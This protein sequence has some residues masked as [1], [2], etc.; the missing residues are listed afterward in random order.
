MAQCNKTNKQQLCC[1]HS[2]NNMEIDTRRWCAKQLVVF[3][4]FCL[5]CFR[6]PQ[7]R[8]NIVQ[9]IPFKD[10]RP[11][12][13]VYNSVKHKTLGCITNENGNT[14]KVCDVQQSGMMRA[15]VCTFF[16]WF[17]ICLG[18][19][20]KKKKAYSA[21]QQRYDDKAFHKLCLIK[22]K[23]SQKNENPECTY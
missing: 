3:F 7:S 21:E 16:V 22:Y 1:A 12:M 10:K 18:F 14:G 20:F 4:F 9:S 19:F 8:S 23:Q 13:D 15:C 11:D 5:F 17:F 6:C 2:K